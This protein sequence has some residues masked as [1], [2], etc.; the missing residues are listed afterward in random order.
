[1]V[2]SCPL[3]LAVLSSASFLQSTSSVYC[4]S[5]LSSLWGQNSLSYG[6]CQQES[7]TKLQQCFMVVVNRLKWDILC[8]KGKKR[9]E[10]HHRTTA[11]HH[12]MT[13]SYL[14]GVYIHLELTSSLLRFALHFRQWPLRWCPSHSPRTPRWVTRLLHTRLERLSSVAVLSMGLFYNQDTPRRGLIPCPRLCYWQKP[15]S[16]FKPSSLLL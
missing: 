9:Q 10:H 7:I 2:F 11:S 13:A 6:K 8:S 12:W 14:P 1:M 4:L 16:E 5:S 15:A 3:T